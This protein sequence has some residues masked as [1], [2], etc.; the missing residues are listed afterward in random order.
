MVFISKKQ[1]EYINKLLDS[2]DPTSMEKK[3]Q[4]HTRLKQKFLRMHEDYWLLVK[5]F[6]EY[7]HLFKSKKGSKLTTVA[8]SKADAQVIQKLRTINIKKNAGCV[9]CKRK[10][11]L[12]IYELESCNECANG[13]NI[14]HY[15]I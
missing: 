1:R 11:R 2:K 10:V 6:K 15:L 7:E 3:Y 5:F 8:L 4:F 13:L 14:R 9:F 12:E